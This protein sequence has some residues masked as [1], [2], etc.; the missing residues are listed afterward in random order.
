M[1][2]TL[3]IAA[4]EIGDR[5]IIFIT[6]AVLGV[7]PFAA[8]LLPGLERFGSDQV[9]GMT[10]AFLTVAYVL[11]LSLTLGASMIGR[12]LTEK[13]LSFY[14][15]RPVSVAAIWFGKLL[16][17]LAT[18]A[19]V[20]AITGVPALLA[21]E[22]SPHLPRALGFFAAGI[23]ALF[24]ISH[25]ASTMIRS[26]S[27]WVLADLAALAVVLTV[28]NAMAAELVIEG[29]AFTVVT[30]LAWC[31]GAAFL[32]ILTIAGAWQ[33]SRGRIDPRR[34]H[35]ELSRF[36]WTTAGLTVAV[37]GAVVL[38]IV[39]VTPDDLDT[40]VDARQVPGSNWVL[41]QGNTANRGDFQ[42]A[43]FRN[44]ASGD[45]ERI[46]G[47]GLWWDGFFTRDGRAG[48]RVRFDGLV[49]SLRFRASSVEATPTN[50]YVQPGD[51]LIASDDATRVAIVSG[52]MVAVKDFP[53]GRTL[54]AAR[55]PAK[56]VRAFFVTPDLM[57]IYVRS[58][59]RTDVFELDVRAKELTKTGEFVADGTVWFN[60]TPDGSRLLARVTSEQS[61]EL[62]ILEGRTAAVMGRLPVKGR[63]E[64]GIALSDGRAATVN[65]NDARLLSIYDGNLA[66]QRQ[67]AL[68]G[69]KAIWFGR[70]LA[71]GRLLIGGHAGGRIDAQQGRDWAFH[72]VDLNAGRIVRTERGIRPLQME[73][74][75]YYD[76][77]PRRH[78][79]PAGAPLVVLD[80][81][82]KT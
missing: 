42:A 75:G 73:L 51:D 40:S 30:V 19:A 32:V 65:A 63:H 23:L 66:L 14:F 49:E 43:F 47:T 46:K 78:V 67:V 11:A 57:R 71:G 50:L 55:L 54:A 38:W 69:L 5:R 41:L 13:R 68:P 62:L 58:E 76:I 56:Y 20:A 17:G 6:A 18:V 80:A 82:G 39:N 37:A 7:A 8:V 52:D 22:P 21:V 64:F 44:V 45:Y 25:V 1:K 26:R 34:N 24:L 28:L 2:K 29:K 27:P 35:R 61:A 10:G 79:T 9:I 59:Q 74:F 33:L 36:L 48:A 3:A 81:K 72:F 77:D 4:R 12:E 16:G 70:E 31:I 53:G 15:A 60:A